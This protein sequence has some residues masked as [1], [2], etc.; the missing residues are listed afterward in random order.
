F[1]FPSLYSCLPQVKESC[2]NG[3]K[4]VPSTREGMYICCSARS[5]RSAP[6][7]SERPVCPASH[8]VISSVRQHL[9]LCSDCKDGV[10]AP[11]R[12]SSISICC[13][14]S[15]TFCG[16]GSSVEMDGLLARD[17]SKLPC[18][19]GYECSLT[20][21]GNRVCCSFAE[22]PNGQ[23]ARAICAE[24][25]SI[26]ETCENIYGQRWCCPIVRERQCPDNRLSNGADCSLTSP[27]CTDGYECM[28]SDDQTGHLC[29]E[30]EDEPV[31]S[32]VTVRAKTFTKSPVVVTF[33]PPDAVTIAALPATS[34]LVVFPP[35]QLISEP[36]EPKCFGDTAPMVMEGEYLRC[37]QI[38]A[39]C[40]KAG[41]SCQATLEGLFCCPMEMITPETVTFPSLT[42]PTVPPAECIDC[43]NNV[44][45]PPT[46]R[47]PFAFKEARHE[48]TDEIKTCAGFLDF[49][50][51]FGYT[52]LPS[53]TTASFLCCVQ[54]SST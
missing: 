53:S 10:C 15:E 35:S 38:G 32:T 27:M 33:A 16:P 54:I 26:D 12:A 2:L 48:T 5:S 31:R 20:P 45:E 34:S 49:T 24:G 14:S 51:P 11:F 8:P 18:S 50:C 17:C 40:P 4:C 43:D 6:K 47:C 23:R 28:E 22:C 42:L 46:P 52:C 7:L 39:P 3:Q 41:Y 19:E 25:C 29:C 21:K 44:T 13:H 1:R 36:N 30:I 9:R 37:P